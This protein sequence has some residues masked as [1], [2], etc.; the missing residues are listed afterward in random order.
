MPVA[1]I[2]RYLRGF[3]PRLGIQT[4]ASAQTLSAPWSSP[5]GRARGALAC[6]FATPPASRTD[7]SDRRRAIIAQR[8]SGRR[9]RIRGET[10]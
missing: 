6:A 8:P 9:R 10:R 3:Q 1:A 7:S 2:S 4:P 5:R